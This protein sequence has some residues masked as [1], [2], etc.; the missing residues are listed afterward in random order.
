ME[1]HSSS[2][3]CGI[4]SRWALE[5]ISRLESPTNRTASSASSLKTHKSRRKYWKAHAFLSAIKGCCPGKCVRLPLNEHEF[6]CFENSM[7]TYNH[8][9]CAFVTAV[10]AFIALTSPAKTAPLSEPDLK[11]LLTGIRAN[12]ST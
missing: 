5:F 6:T 12:R 9:M 1:R 4:F 8:R 2:M 10:L 11:D 7:T 3:A